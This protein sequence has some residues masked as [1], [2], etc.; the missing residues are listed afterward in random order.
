MNLV[1]RDLKFIGKGIAILGVWIGWALAIKPLME[2]ILEI[3]GSDDGTFWVGIIVLLFLYMFLLILV[4]SAT[5]AIL[6]RWDKD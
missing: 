6:D 2:P 5:K 1:D 3:F 4:H